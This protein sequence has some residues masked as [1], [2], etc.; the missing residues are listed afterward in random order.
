MIFN[1]EEVQCF[2]ETEAPQITSQCWKLSPKT[3]EFL[4]HIAKKN[5][6]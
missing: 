6:N 3:R 5:I 1:S 2:P 4:I